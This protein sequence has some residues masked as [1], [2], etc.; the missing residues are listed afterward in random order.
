MILI[1]LGGSVITDKSA[2]KRFNK[3]IVSRLCREIKGSK[4]EVIIVHGAGS[5]GHVLAKEFELQK[6]HMNNGQIDA[7]AKVSRD[8]REL[9]GMIVSEL[10]SAGIPSVSVPTGS[11]FVMDDNELLINDDEVLR[12]YVR[13]GIMPVMFGDVVLDRK[14]GFGICSGD[15]VMRSLAILF[16]PEAVVF[17]SDIDG[18]YDRDPK[19]SKDAKLITDVDRDALDRIPPEMTVADVTG[20]VHAKMRTMLDMCSDGRDCILVNGTVDGRLEELLT[21]KKVI[22][23]RAR[24]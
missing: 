18:L 6:G 3:D 4:K 12:G 10:I 15:A 20:G 24:K 7:V 17:V 14:K 2:Y 9:N 22:C 5:F 11:C 16:E 1:K 23:T 13:L 8:V 19:V 21:G